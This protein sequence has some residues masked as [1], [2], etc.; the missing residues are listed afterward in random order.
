MKNI[1]P[2]DSSVSHFS[3][4]M[5]QKRLWFLQAL[6]P[7]SL[8]FVLT[9]AFSIPIDKSVTTE[10][11]ESTLNM[12]F[13][14]NQSLRGALT[15]TEN[16]TARQF[17]HSAELDFL[18]E[19]FNKPVENF[20]KEVSEKPFD[21]KSGKCAEC[22]YTV[23]QQ[24]TLT[25]IIRVHA[26]F[27]N[28]LTLPLLAADFEN[29]LN[30]AGVSKD[31]SLSDFTEYQ[32]KFLSSESATEK[33]LYWKSKFSKQPQELDLPADRG[34]PQMKNH[35]GS[36]FE[37]A[38][39]E[40]LTNKIKEYTSKNNLS[41]FQFVFSSVSALFHRYTGNTEITAGTEMLFSE[42]PNG[43]AGAFLNY[44]P[45]KLNF[46]TS[47]DFDVFYRHSAAE[48]MKSADNGDIPFSDIIDNSHSV[49]NTS[50]N[51]LFDFAVSEKISAET[52][53][54][55]LI[56]QEKTHSDYD[57]EISV[58]CSE[59]VL[60]EIVYD[61]ALFDRSR[62]EKL[63]LHL[64]VFISSALKNTKMTISE[65]EILT[66]NEK[67]LLIKYNSTDHPFPD[68][69]TLAS[70]FETT[71]KKNS[72]C[73]ALLFDGKSTT[74]SELEKMSGN[75]A[76]AL[77]NRD[78]KNYIGIMAE[79][80][81]EMIAGILG[82]IRAG[83]AYVPLN[84][85][86]PAQRTQWMLEDTD[87]PQVL[88]SKKYA[89][90]FS[91]SKCELLFF[92]DIKDSAYSKSEIT[93][94]DS[95]YIIFTS[96]ST[97]RP[98]GV[99]IQHKAIMNRLFWMQDTFTLDSSDVILQKTPYS[100]DVSVW[101]IFWWSHCGA[102]LAILPP[103]A[104]K[105][106]ESIVEF[107]SENCCTVLH[108]VPSMLNQF[109]NYLEMEPAQTAKLKTLKYVFA[110]GEAL[111][112]EL[113]AKFDR[114]I[115]K[116]MQAEL[117]NLY[118]PTEAAVDVTWHPC[119]PHN[120]KQ[121]EIPIGKPVYNT[122]IHIL[123][124]NGNEMPP[125]VDG[126]IHLG[127]VQL[128][129]GYINREKLTSEKFVT[130]R[131]ERLY[132]TGD[133]G[134]IG[135]DGSIIFLGRL[136]GQVKVRG[137]RIETGEVENALMKVKGIKECAVDVVTL[138]SKVAE[139][140]A[141]VSAD[142]GL[143]T[144]DIKGALS[145]TLQDYMIPTKI[146]S[147]DNIP[148]NPN[149]KADKKALLKQNRLLDVTVSS[150][151][152]TETE[153]T[154]SDIWK[155]LLEVPEVG[156]DVN[157][158][159]S[160]GNSLLLLS[161]HEALEARWKGV[162]RI[163]E[164]F[165]YTTIKEISAEID[166][167]NVSKTAADKRK[168]PKELSR[169]AL[170]GDKEAI[171]M[172]KEMGYLKT[173][174]S[175]TYLAPQGQVALWA[176]EQF[177]PE[178]SV[179]HIPHSFEIP[180]E[181][182]VAD[183]KN[184]LVKLADRQQILKSCI[185]FEDGKNLLKVENKLNID[186]DNVVIE[187]EKEYHK[188]L[189]KKFIQR[190]N[191]A[192]VPL[193]RATIAQSKSEK[194]K[195]LVL[196]FHHIIIDG[197]SINIFTSEFLEIL[198]SGSDRNL[199]KLNAQY[200][201]YADNYNK[202]L[203]SPKADKLKNFWKEYASNFK[204]IEMPYDFPKSSIKSSKGGLIMYKPYAGASKAV[205]SL[206][207]KENTAFAVFTSALN[208]MFGKLCG[209][210]TLAVSVP[211]H[212]R[213][214]EEYYPLIGY[215][216]NMIPI[217]TKIE[218]GTTVEELIKKTSS[219]IFSVLDHQE[220]PHSMIA[221]IVKDTANDSNAGFLDI[222]VNIAED[223]AEILALTDIKKVSLGSRFDLSFYITR[224]GDE[225]VAGI[226]Y[227]SGLYT[228]RTINLFCERL[229]YVL[230]EM[231]EKYTSP[232][233]EVAVVAPE[234]LESL[235]NLNPKPSAMPETNVI[236]R[237][238]EIAERYPD[239]TAVR[240][241]PK[242]LSYKELKAESI[243][244][245]SFLQNDKSAEP[246]DIICVLC[247]RIFEIPAIYLGI[248]RSGCIFMPADPNW[249]D[250]RLD[251]LIKDSGCKTV[252]SNRA[253]KKISGVQVIDIKTAY[254]EKPL[255][256]ID[257]SPSEIAYIIYTSGSTGTPKGVKIRHGSLTSASE[258]GSL[259]GFDPKGC[260]IQ[261]V[262][263]IFDASILGIFLPLL[264]GGCFTPLTILNMADVD[265]FRNVAEANRC[266][267]MVT[268]Y[269][270]FKSFVSS[271]S[272]IFKYI[273]RLMVGGEIL[274]P[275]LVGRATDSYP[276]LVIINGYGPTESTV[277]CATHKIDNT[278]SYDTIPIGRPVKDARIYI[279]D[280]N[281][282]IL[283]RGAW[284]ELCVAGNILSS[285]YLNREEL[286]AKHFAPLISVDEERVYFTGDIAKWNR[287][288]ELEFK[289]R[290]DSQVKIRGVRIE[291]GEIEHSL[292]SNPSVKDCVVVKTELSD[293]VVELVAFVT[294]SGNMTEQTL[295][296]Y[297][298][299]IL[300]ASNVPS[301][302]IF[303]DSIPLNSS[304][305]ADRDKL[306]QIALKALQ[307]QSIS[308]HKDYSEIHEQIYSILQAVLPDTEFD[309]DSNFFDIS[310][311]SIL[312]IDLFNRI[313]AIYPDKIKIPDL[314][315]YTTVNEISSF[316]KGEQ[317]ETVSAKT[318]N[319]SGDIAVIGMAVRLSDYDDTES[320]W[321]DLLYACD[322]VGEIPP[323]RKKQTLDIIDSDGAGVNFFESA[324]L[325]DISLFDPL[326]YGI[327]PAEAVLMDSEQKLF[328]MLCMSALDDA[329]S[330]G[331]TLRHKKVGVFAGSSPSSIYRD[332]I[333]RKY[334]ERIEQAF[335]VTV[336]SSTA[337]RLSYLMD[338]KGPAAMVDTACSSSLNAVHLA[339]NAL[340]N[341][342]C[343][344]ALA[345]GV[346]VSY[347]PVDEG[348][349]FA[350][351]SKKSRAYTF[352]D[353][354]DGTGMG[355]GGCAILLKPLSKA[356]EDGDS[357]HAVIKGS[358]VNQDGRSSGPAAPNPKA[359]T[360]LILNA[361]ANAGVTA[362]TIG[363]I[364][365]HGT[366]TKLG[367]PIE[368]DAITKAFNNQTSMK[369][370]AAIGSVKGNFGH[371]DS[372]AGILGFVKAVLCVKNEK[373]PPQ[374]FYTT[375][376]K[377]IDFENSPVFVPESI[378]PFPK[379]FS[380]RRAGVS[381]FGL[382]GVN[383]HVIIEE[384]PKQM[385][386]E[387]EGMQ[388]FLL[389]APDDELLRDYCGRLAISLVKN[390]C[391]LTDLAYTLAYGRPV[392]KKR[393]VII[394]KG[395]EILIK[396]LTSVS[397]GV[398]F[399]EGAEIYFDA[400]GEHKIFGSL[401]ID[402][403]KKAK[404]PASLTGKRIHIPYSKNKQISVWPKKTAVKKQSAVSSQLISA[405]VETPDG[406]SFSMNVSS[407][408][409]WPI[410][411]HIL[412]G[413]PVMAGMA[414]I[415]IFKSAAQ[416]AGLA[417]SVEVTNLKWLSPLRPEDFLSPNCLLKLDTKNQ[418]FAASLMYKAKSGAWN[419]V[420]MADIS[421]LTKFSEKADVK[422]WQNSCSVKNDVTFL[423]DNPIINVSD[424]W[425]C[426]KEKRSD[427][428]GILQYGELELTGASGDTWRDFNP[429][430]ID[431]G[432]SMGLKEQYV[433][434]FC[435]SVEIIK[436]LPEKIF[437]LTETKY[438]ERNKTIY[439][440]ALFTDDK[441]DV[442][443][444][445]KEIG[446]KKIS[447]Q[448]IPLFR[449][450]WQ[451]KPVNSEAQTVL[452]KLL[453]ACGEQKY[454]KKFKPELEDA[455][456]FVPETA[457]IDKSL[458]DIINSS[459]GARLIYFHETDESLFKFISELKTVLKY[460]RKPL[461]FLSVTTG[462]FRVK[463]E[464]H[465]FENIKR[466]LFNG[467][468]RAVGH[469]SAF[470]KAASIDCDENTDFRT[471]IAEF[472]E[473]TP[474]NIPMKTRAV[475][476][477]KRYVR[478][479][480]IAPEAE[481]PDLVT[482]GGSY[483]I[484]GGSGGVGSAFAAYLSE[485]G[486]KHIGILSKNPKDLS[487]CVHTKQT[488]MHYIKCDA[489]D[490][491]QLK[492]AVKSFADTA[493]LINGVIHAAG[494]PGDGFL[495]NKD[496]ATFESVL[497]PKVEATINLYE[498][499]SDYSPEYI[500]LCSSGT[501]LTGAPG[502]TDYT[503][504]NT[505]QDFFAESLSDD[506][507]HIISINWPMW[508][509][510]GMAK[511]LPEELSSKY[512]VTPKNGPEVAETALK[513]GAS[514]IIPAADPRL[515]S[516]LTDE[517]GNRQSNSEK[518][519]SKE[520]KSSASIIKQITDT[521]C[522]ELD[523]K[524]L[525]IDDD[526]YEIG[527]D[528]LSAMRIASKLT[529]ELGKPVTV[530]DIFANPTIKEL[531]LFLGGDLAEN[532][533][534]SGVQK[535]PEQE[536]YLITSG[537]EDIFRYQTISPENT[538][539]NLSY[540]ASFNTTI[541]ADRLIKSLKVL[542]DR[543][544]IFKASFKEVSG[545]IRMYINEDRELPFEIFDLGST[546]KRIETAENFI[547]PFNLEKDTLIRTALLKCD[548]K[549]DVLLFDLHH[550]IGDGNTLEILMDELK[551]IYFGNEL[552]DKYTDTIDFIHWMKSIESSKVWEQE[553]KFWLA[554]FPD[555]ITDIYFP[556][557]RIRPS[558]LT[559][560]GAL[561]SIIIEADKLKRIRDYAKKAKTTVYTLMTT[562]LALVLT[563]QAGRED[564]VIYSA[565]SLRDKQEFVNVPGLLINT[566]PLCIE[567]KPDSSISENIKNVASII[568]DSLRYKLVGSGDIKKELGNSYSENRFKFG[569]II[570]SYMNYS[571]SEASSGENP[572]LEMLGTGDKASAKAEMSF[573]GLETDNKLHITVEYYADAY[574]KN[575]IDRICSLYS[576]LIDVI[577]DSDPQTL[578]KDISEIPA[579][580]N[581]KLLNE[582]S[583]QFMG[584]PQDKSLVALFQ[585]T[586]L[587]HPDNIAIED[588][589][590]KLSYRELDRI[591][592]YSAKIIKKL[593]TKHGE[594]VAVYADRSID[595]VTAILGIIK[596]DCCYLPIDDS[597]PADR[598][599]SIIKSAGCSI[600]ISE[601]NY[602][603]S[604]LT[605][606]LLKDIVSGGEDEAQVTESD[607]NSMA[608]IMFTSGS[609]GEPKGTMIKHLSV[610]RL[611]R[612][613]NYIEFGS[614]DK[615][616]MGGTLAFDA[617]TLEI[618]G[619][620]LNGGTLHIARKDQL[621][622]RTG[623]REIINSH[624][625]TKMW[626]TASL[627]NAEADKDPSIFANLKV[628]M[629]GGE[630]LSVKHVEKVM[631]ACPELTLMNCYGPTEN[632]TFT[633]THVITRDDLKS[634]IPIG[635]PIANTSVYILD[636]RQRP[637]P[638]GVWGE[639]AT[640][641]YGVGEGY[642]NDKELTNKVFIDNPFSEGKLYLSGDIGRFRED[643][644]IEFFGRKDA[645]IKIR[646][647]RVELSEVET[648][649][650]ASG[651]AKQAAAFIEN[652]ETDKFLS[653]CVTGFDENNLSSLRAYLMR[654][655][656]TYMIP[657]RY[658]LVEEIP[659][660]KNGKT[661]RASLPEC[662]ANGK[663]IKQTVENTD[664]L[665]AKEKMVIECFQKIMELEN[666]SSEDN[667]F[668]LGGH[669]LQAAKIIAMIQD[670]CGYELS[671]SKFMLNPVVKNIAALIEDTVNT[672]EI[673]KAEAA[674]DYPL[675]YAQ[676]RLYSVCQLEGASAAYNINSI[677]K[678]DSSLDLE[679]FKKTARILIEKHE[680][681][682]TYFI[683]KDG[684]I[685]QKVAE[686]VPLPLKIVYL[687]EVG[688]KNIKDIISKELDRSFDLSEPPLIRFCMWK[689]LDGTWTLTFVIHHIAADGTSFE[690]FLSDMTEIYESLLTKGEYIYDEESI[691]Y[692]DFSIW[693][694]KF[695]FTEELESW[696]YKLRDV[697]ESVEL[698]HDFDVPLRRKFTGKT[699]LRDFDKELSDKLHEI[700]SR[701][702]IT[703][704]SMMMG[705]FAL[706][707]N[708]L[709][710]QDDFCI[711]LGSASRH[712][713]A[714]QNILGFFVNLMPIR[715]KFD[716]ELD[717]QEY[718]TKTYSEILAALELQ[719]CPFDL[720][721]DKVLTSRSSGRQP[722][723]N[724]GFEYETF[725]MDNSDKSTLQFI[726]M[727]KD[728]GTIIFQDSSKF[729]AT[730][731]VVESSVGLHLKLEFDTEL[732]S[733]QSAERWLD[734]YNEFCENI[735][736]MLYE[737]EI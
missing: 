485:K 203:N 191:L 204:K 546:D 230:C 196:I 365:A 275:S 708:K 473:F 687:D 721:I 483:L 261:A 211:A 602:K 232:V 254:S 499:V 532:N 132:K 172:L 596:A 241:L 14:N 639:I 16:N 398:E 26:I 628:L 139:L 156:L 326:R 183:V 376:N 336:P 508:L 674:E 481:G 614:D 646:G 626:L 206:I 650:T 538:S 29:I 418:S 111:T 698:P 686:N 155:K 563:R 711:A 456:A 469:E 603:N 660:N 693:Q 715:F 462:S 552:P 340:R 621:L 294:A 506:K 296:K 283:P 212:G 615:I 425:L 290:K 170:K 63:M 655:I 301:R 319:N 568:G 53:R 573:F 251:F 361:W 427:S 122:K 285:G 375:P 107:I 239:K 486:A 714:L 578:I 692:K 454:L 162:F 318:I 94:D 426:L 197:W 252:I 356:V 315:R 656:P 177:N 516:W 566:V 521:W 725:D 174:G 334:P 202:L 316:I 61:N 460:V 706:L 81:I 557:D 221:D 300:P 284:G 72:D 234:E 108:F 671:I 137:F 661:E 649:V 477:G 127:G 581:E 262:P 233:S 67:K 337:T 320:L 106:P 4:T 519:V 640:G 76:A 537:Q 39:P 219:N 526:F 484:T 188:L 171:R 351:Q 364:E 307:N 288:D 737:Q 338:W 9:H 599:N 583:G 113:S 344:Y 547:Q 489:G 468:M 703:F 249:P 529:T 559:F 447:L 121:T 517:N 34:R 424:K 443:L 110:S 92:E 311:N 347:V 383:C 286:N 480:E 622:S 101:E 373:I 545:E 556:E 702:N 417:G 380:K 87:Y 59:S 541:E 606:I 689:H 35:S 527:G 641:G 12:L 22:Y 209:A 422:R 523:Y 419:T 691:N 355:E 7:E 327:S 572:W 222:V 104:E 648:A 302:I 653:V 15:L 399:D 282:N 55:N 190:F 28:K 194:S 129:K 442:S 502:Q 142:D 130:I 718:F 98:K 503:S 146:F 141:W 279:V 684:D 363:Y 688:E 387:D 677:V 89:D 280:S 150:S 50:R 416:Q 116:H 346:K 392:L 343:E 341:G 259:T 21:I 389:S 24:N 613:T 434:A 405:P 666:I 308:E 479:Y 75:I 71:A 228:E 690:I 467:M 553:K 11:I 43:K 73:A 69:E 362:D 384:A 645:Q 471:I 724:I 229:F 395:K 733:Q 267:D 237:F 673:P 630:R 409:F 312:V 231:E 550:I 635:R 495:V 131:G 276:D 723:T 504:A 642:I 166:A 134:R 396:A 292:L 478:S 126:E 238:D 357:I 494:V 179:Y 149:G 352:D 670:K 287:N 672:Y 79:R 335:S 176:W 408:E 236:D 257:I 51:P 507:I 525:D 726:E 27:V 47:T 701:L 587:K 459:E 350:I 260:F 151:D 314:F 115:G 617:S 638:V 189:E 244:I 160:G 84:P 3:L 31:S 637:A 470:L 420:L 248:L 665:D 95:A 157:F 345:G 500:I 659:V 452:P 199:P 610:T 182:T 496:D 457:S 543:H 235:K 102:S 37:H 678:V 542:F 498:A 722:L 576:S 657:S 214:S 74:Y 256:S 10:K 143:S 514:G 243:K 544:K 333:I 415:N 263:L 198:K 278:K 510:T 441:G 119:T 78:T 6:A 431:C 161:L 208:I 105:N 154:V 310:G 669:S 668:S 13:K 382:S 322:K 432:V 391:S 185:I 133:K 558:K 388:F 551:N 465:H 163:A 180:F 736:E 713:P 293:E 436:P 601:D 451:E 593:G 331:E 549:K 580:E 518:E 33:T 520:K 54:V 313:N 36:V 619:A 269:G 309:M 582:F 410:H 99:E 175:K 86:Y 193:F 728:L 25:V 577:L 18:P 438:N 329:G 173:G 120:E 579:E 664:D 210:E 325:N 448:N 255:R 667:F 181:T 435:K 109:L 618:W 455:G 152:I 413:S 631:N 299:T 407:A 492:S 298:G 531:T 404:L 353:N 605:N 652:S 735:A 727:D 216:V 644:V 712:H 379:V 328:M 624:G 273:K 103:G 567:T 58:E 539:F 554:K 629:T 265:E 463:N 266:T 522:R 274:N 716:E 598:V 608:Y 627:F 225:W 697:P 530:T 679:I 371:L 165:T 272:D 148:L 30:G 42:A 569:E 513:T 112:A 472:N 444:R 393:I 366:G 487:A 158:F 123:D 475:R 430:V 730:L 140:A 643:G 482:E 226:E 91:D 509:D 41:V 56:K 449:K 372:A 200:F 289:G 423:N 145:R 414:V 167:K 360:E 192:A 321:T 358:A 623:L 68:T 732:F 128:A 77:K 681:L 138:S 250:S 381:S 562:A 474:E 367:D 511:N 207:K 548:N 66:E 600:I 406:F 428:N 186:I 464:I 377:E 90:K 49:K 466:S 658:Y 195:K 647:N 385:M 164:L 555:G 528:S 707:I 402:F 458:T 695:D 620:L 663:L 533:P 565:S 584:F 240:L 386:T 461:F 88:T 332:F 412:S 46:K 93:P 65:A 685:R 2:Y 324:Y 82:I 268:S 421:P 205:S 370:F 604:E 710:N 491:E 453:I 100:F 85:D 227:N 246:G 694:N 277:I 258:S 20:I 651:Y 295:K 83:M 124:Q 411:E 590:K 729:D 317:E 224:S 397:A 8:D 512:G 575:Y 62:I 636:N 303:L 682:R 433:P 297:L 625:I 144:K 5:N 217:I 125:G 634:N 497:R 1:N 70:A 524:K 437:C 570:F 264:N 586:A 271:G 505:F 220:Y 705:I 97:G 153:Q 536:Y 594:P 699:I 403:I 242:E 589:G 114:I 118:G 48:M 654:T 662:A 378:I 184:A 683:E 429:A 57:L 612:N 304:S 676:R 390:S 369:Q 731:Y 19:P 515:L 709:S 675:S 501:A 585:E 45:V 450:M 700:S 330:G 32:Y 17:F 178:S 564:M 306:T 609:T 374:P 440:D 187:N 611:V 270:I 117:H 281:R 368:I 60:F 359:Q 136:D 561:T 96:G 696:Q 348:L 169:R 488:N 354:A 571:Q 476:N 719:H 446:F 632:T 680:I 534:T 44:V 560:K 734:Y 588:D 490:K 616:L 159:D 349:D 339:C 595:S 218:D 305:K 40:S 253:D 342:E 247:D 633:T 147:V 592:N 80:S 591:S 291:I 168:D 245:A 445:F 597:A 717:V 704:N 394:T 323:E 135:D 720:V 213:Y 401:I 400:E 223:V 64:E 201:D 439:T 23:T 38:F 607:G 535:A 574:S 215:F 493:G 52:E 540:F